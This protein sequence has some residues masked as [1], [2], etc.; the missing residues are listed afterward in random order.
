MKSYLMYYTVY[1]NTV[2]P[3]SFPRMLKVLSTYVYAPILLRGDK[4]LYPPSSLTL[5]NLISVAILWAVAPM[6]LRRD[7]TSAS[8]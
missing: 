1:K 8:T 6:L 5:T 3:N 2:Y 7:I 4:H